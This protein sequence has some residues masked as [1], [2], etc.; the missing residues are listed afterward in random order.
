MSKQAALE[1]AT[2][3]SMISTRNSYL[4][5]QL[6]TALRRSRWDAGTIARRAYLSRNTMARLL[7]GDTTLSLAVYEMVAE[8]LETSLELI[9]WVPVG[10]LNSEHVIE[11][12][13]DGARRGV[14]S[15]PLDR[16]DGI[17]KLPPEAPPPSID[18]LSR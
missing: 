13:V 5:K 18:E 8:E 16:L 4:G 11:T 2:I 14:K 6:R 10:N 3:G 12:V 17:L 9:P 1:D 7:V 15:K